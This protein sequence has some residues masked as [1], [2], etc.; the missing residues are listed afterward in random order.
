[1]ANRFYE[2][3]Q[4]RAHSASPTSDLGKAWK[5]YLV[6]WNSLLDKDTPT[7]FLDEE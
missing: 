6:K 7:S 1:M 3:R 5:H 4:L 2:L